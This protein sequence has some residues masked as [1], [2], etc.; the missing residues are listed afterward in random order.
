[1]GIINSLNEELLETALNSG[2]INYTQFLFTKNLLKNTEVNVLTLLLENN[3]ITQ[4]QEDII[5]KNYLEENQF[6]K[7]DVRFGAIAHKLFNVSLNDIKNAL[8]Y[9][10]Q[11][12]KF[13]PLRLGEILVLHGKLTPNEVMKIVE[14]QESK[15]ITC[16]CGTS[17]NFFK[18]NKGKRVKCYK[19]SNELVVPPVA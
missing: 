19:C 16:I 2:F 3:Y 13:I 8:N 5:I 12:K 18:F 11:V 14:L 15:I 6:Y 1:M 10:K 17:Y 9:Q 4:Q 7:Q